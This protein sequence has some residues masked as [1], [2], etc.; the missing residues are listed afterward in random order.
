MRLHITIP[1]PGSSS[2]SA[3]NTTAATVITCNP[4]PVY[5]KDMP[6]FYDDYKTLCP[7]WAWFYIQTAPWCL[8]PTFD[9]NPRGWSGFLRGSVAAASINK[10]SSTAAR[11]SST[12]S[13]TA[14]GSTG[15]G[16]IPVCTYRA[17]LAY[18]VNVSDLTVT[19]KRLFDAVWDAQVCGTG[20]TTHRWVNASTQ[21]IDGALTRADVAR[22]V[23][24]TINLK[25]EPYF[26]G[27][28]KT[29]YPKW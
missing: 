3:A 22:L 9:L 7:V 28:G 23:G 12:G 24:R 18:V 26:M 13:T 20:D 15:T 10:D 1:E 6:G 4:G 17:S 19:V 5:L 25:P 27:Y 21:Y 16:V 11:D 2:S 14:R 8:R 29:G